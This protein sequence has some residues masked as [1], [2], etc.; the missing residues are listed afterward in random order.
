MKA[1]QG[2]SS[3]ELTDLL[4]KCTALV[5]RIVQVRTRARTGIVKRD[6]EERGKGW[7]RRSNEKKMKGQKEKEKEKEKEEDDEWEIQWGVS[8]WW[9]SVSTRR[10]RGLIVLT[11]STVLPSV[12]LIYIHYYDILLLMLYCEMDQVAY[13]RSNK[14][15][16]ERIVLNLLIYSF[17]A[18]LFC[19]F[20]SRWESSF[21]FIR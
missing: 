13:V 14:L 4:K 6:F 7:C 11:Y 9:D 18:I 5:A 8:S 15:E 2:N 3:T 21:R 16:I 1:C 10:N 17:Y 12:I 20:S 19:F